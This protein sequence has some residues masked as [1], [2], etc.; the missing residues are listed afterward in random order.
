MT[1]SVRWLALLVF[2]DAGA[3]GARAPDAAHAVARAR[4]AR[5]LGDGDSLLLSVRQLRERLTR[6]GVVLLHLGEPA[7]YDAGHIPGARFLPY[8]TIA[9]DRGGRSL[10]LPPAATLKELL[11]S[12][13]VSSD[14]RIVLYWSKGWYSPTARVFLTLDYYGL[15]ERTSILDGGF[16]A[17][18]AAGGP[19]TTERPKLERGS[20][21]VRPRG[22][23][24][25]DA[26]TVREAIGNPHIAIVDARDPRFYAGQ[27]DG[28]R[29]RSGHIPGAK[30][31]PFNSLIDESGALEPLAT[32]NQL[33]EAAGATPTRR[34]VA[35]CHIGQ[36]ASLVYFAARLL[37]RDVRLYD[38][39][40]D[41]W[42]RR[43][44][45]PIETGAAI[46]R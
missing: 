30:S 36:Q 9:G 16:A 45:L 15:G 32:L 11:E 1:F 24:I 13:G 28:M 44:D 14:S 12:L 26:A 41:E 5:P 31:L 40:W 7:D 39:S 6:P 34:I 42:A 17:W 35:Y 46:A 27:S 10:E 20:V 38:G 37:G 19:V 33:F 3:T 22:D 8:Q 18:M 25:V 2:L 43:T 21:S 23:V 4:Q 29:P